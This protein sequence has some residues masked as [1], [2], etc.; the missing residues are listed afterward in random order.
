MGSPTPSLSDARASPAALAVVIV[1]ALL[2]VIDIARL[3]AAEAEADGRPQLAAALAPAAPDSL[4]SSAMAQVGEA[5][6]TSNDPP[7]ATMANLRRLSLSAP[8]RPEPFLVEAA[9]AE[10]AGD[11]K[12]A[13]TLL[14]DARL[15]DPRS[16]A[17]R[18]LLADVQ[19]RQNKVASG[20]REMAILA[21]LV[22]GS[23]VQLV[24]ALSEF[25]RSPNARASLT[26]ILNANATLRQPLLTA[27]AADP[28]NADLIVA[29][30][31]TP[32]PFGPDHDQQWQ[33]RLL[34]TLV[35][36]G[37]YNRAYDVWRQ[38]ARLGNHPRPLIYNAD[39]ADLQAPPPFNWS[40]TSGAAGV[41][42]P[43]KGVLRV[44]YY[45]RNT[46][47]LA[48]QLLLLPRGTYRFTTSVSGSL[49]SGALSWTVRCASADDPLMQLV[50]GSNAGETATFTVSASNCPAQKLA[51]NGQM[52]D[53]LDQSDV[54]IG[55]A[56]IEKVGN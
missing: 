14:I 45:G 12:R 52:Q 23:A 4:A 46:A 54:R 3:T 42:E 11:Y 27:L 37:D 34:K 15:R 1:V 51:L 33:S 10:K 13:E 53:S 39:Y 44:L 20:L 29:L 24:P 17:A 31:A 26:A 9:L 28:D 48:S 36:R 7:A 18:Y 43:D 25:A 30:A 35:E 22:P 2:L 49:Q 47:E 21:R 8:L 55:P 40:F 50:L 6:A 5:A 32:R 41:V 56:N 19:L 16:A 38:F